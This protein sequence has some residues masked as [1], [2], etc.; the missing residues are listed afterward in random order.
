MTALSE[1]ITSV[2]RMP[3]NPNAV[4]LH[5]FVNVGSRGCFVREKVKPRHHD[6]E[7]SWINYSVNNLDRMPLPHHSVPECRT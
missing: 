6:E 3:V 1:L 7:Y 4:G 5:H 2:P